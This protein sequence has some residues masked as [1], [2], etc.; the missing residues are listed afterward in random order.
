[1]YTKCIH[2][3]IGKVKVGSKLRT[4]NHNFSLNYAPRDKHK[5]KDALI[6]IYLEYTHGTTRK[7]LSTLV[8]VPKGSWRLKTRS[9]DLKTYPFLVEAQQRLDEIMSKTYPQA[10]LLAKKQTSLE[11]ALDEI[12]SR[13]PD[14][15]MLEYYEEWYKKTNGLNFGTFDNRRKMLV[16]IQKKMLKLGYK[17]YSVIKF[18]HFAD[19]TSL[20]RIANIIKKEFGLEPNGSYGYLKRLDEI[21]NKKYRDSSPFKKAG[22]RGKYERP[23]REGVE[24]RDM[25]AGISRIETLQDLEAYLFFLYS[26]CLRG[27]S[28]KDI[29]QMRDEDFEGVDT[30]PYIPNSNSE[31]HIEKQYYLKR[32][33]KSKNKMRILSN[34]YPTPF[35]KE[36]LRWCVRVNRPEL[37]PSANEGYAIYKKCKN[38]QE[39]SRVWDNNLRSTYTGKLRNLIGKGF[40]SARHTYS[41][42][43]E[44]LGLSTSKLQSSV[45]HVPNERRGKSISSYARA[46]IQELD[47]IHIDIM[48]DFQIITIYFTLCEFL[49][50]KKPFRSKRNSFFPK[51]FRKEHNQLAW[52]QSERLTLQGWTYQKEFRLQRLEERHSDIVHL[53][54]IKAGYIKVTPNKKG[55]GLTYEM[56]LGKSVE[57]P[58]SKEL[59]ELR[60]EKAE[61]EKANN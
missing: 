28:G 59:E 51:W 50:D 42:I 11:T 22:L 26:F 29:F 43:G 4:K 47:L 8:K 52:M 49:K 10:Q 30:E 58:V 56:T 38:E 18:E 46:R 61:L 21:Y 14:Q 16:G 36:L 39:L 37:S 54:N 41:Q 13:M 45:G 60:K 27:L 57:I 3:L 35:I 6:T 33:S 40:H 32:R 31:N 9:I 44:D 12:L 24:F 55:A 1:L 17:E 5:S 53:E 25:L 48:D 2:L 7:R 20:E 23:E 34:L 19:S 15:D